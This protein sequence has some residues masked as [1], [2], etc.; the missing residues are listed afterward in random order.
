MMILN[1]NRALLI[2]NLFSPLEL[3]EVES[4]MKVKVLK[5]VRPWSYRHMKGPWKSCHFPVQGVNP[6]SLG[7]QHFA[8]FLQPWPCDIC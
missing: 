8:R 4:D 6:L 2:F 7:L 1:Q 3:T 5:P